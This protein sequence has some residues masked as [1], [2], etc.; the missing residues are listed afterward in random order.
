M[1]VRRTNEGGAGMVTITLDEHQTTLLI[2]QVVAVDVSLEDYMAHYAGDFCEWIEGVVIDVAGSELRHVSLTFYLQTLLSVYFEL[3]PIGRV[4][5]M[6]FVLRLPA[7]P[8]RRREPDLMVILNTN[9]HELKNTYMDGAPDICIEIVSE[10]SDKRDYGDKFKE[11]EAGG[12]P[13]Y[14]IID[15]LRRESLF[16]RL[17]TEG[18]Y[19]LNLPDAEGIY[20]TPALPALALHVPTLWS[21]PLPGP[22]AIVESVRALLL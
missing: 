19:S 9:P 11:Y 13:E 4:I 1:T 5:G 12:V 16:Y 14:W 8:R 15:P 7:F 21:D 10:E 17:N 3:R 22:A 2:G 18:R 20:R 6:P